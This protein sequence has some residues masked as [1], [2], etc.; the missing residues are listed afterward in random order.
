MLKCFERCQ[1]NCDEPIVKPE[2]REPKEKEE[3]TGSRRIAPE[4]SPSKTTP[5]SMTSKLFQ[6]DSCLIVD[7]S[8][9]NR[10]LLLKHLGP[11]FKVVRT[12]ENGLEAIEEVKMMMEENRTFDLIC[13]DSVM[14]V[15]RSPSTFH[16]LLSQKIS[17]GDGWTRS[18][19]TNQKD[20]ILW[21]GG[22]GNW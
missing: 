3:I 11:H 14:P 5:S 2:L 7:D 22:W 12:A 1:D 13:L 6:L 19:C 4:P 21:I 15:S 18:H 9:L 17:S 10:K 16:F 20:E 8:P